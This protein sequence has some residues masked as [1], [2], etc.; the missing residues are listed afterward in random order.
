MGSYFRNTHVGEKKKDSWKKSF[1]KG[2]L[3]FYCTQPM[4]NT[5]REYE[6]ANS[7]LWLRQWLTYWD[8]TWQ[9]SPYSHQHTSHT[10]HININTI[11]I[12][13]H[14]QAPESSRL[15]RTATWMWATSE[16]ESELLSRAV[17]TLMEPQ[18]MEL[19]MEWKNELNETPSLDFSAAHR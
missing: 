18:A 8:V 12:I 13:Q 16:P 19:Q 15:G 14:T 2:V 17:D 1:K 5:F 4:R 9:V 10:I 6:S 3:Y 11:I 7:H